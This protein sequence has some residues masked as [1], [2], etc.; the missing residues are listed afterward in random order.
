M[1]E[2]PSEPIRGALL[3]VGAGIDQYLPLPG[4]EISA[5]DGNNNKEKFISH[6]SP[7]RPKFQ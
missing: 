3:F 5:Q 1:K 6:R 2:K 4:G 7:L